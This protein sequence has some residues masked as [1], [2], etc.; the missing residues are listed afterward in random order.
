MKFVYII[1]VDLN[2]IEIAGKGSDRLQVW[3]E[4][5]SRSQADL[6]N[7][8]PL[9]IVKILPHPLLEKLQ[10]TLQQKIEENASLPSDH[11]Q[12]E[13]RFKEEDVF[14]KKLIFGQPYKLYTSG[15]ENT[16]T[17]LAN[18][19]NFIMQTPNSGL[20]EVTGSTHSEI[21]RILSSA[22]AGSV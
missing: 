19:Y 17:F 3:N 6:D 13:G 4:I 20:F 21:K 7:L 18:I 10:L 14:V 9:T 2:I 8:I 22:S 1:D 12:W 16:I 15:R 11:S 5:L